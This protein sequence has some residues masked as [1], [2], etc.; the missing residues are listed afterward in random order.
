MLTLLLALTT[1]QAKP[2]TSSEFD[3]TAHTLKE[4]QKQ[5]DVFRE[6][7]FA[8]SKELELKTTFLSWV[9]GPNAGLEYAIRQNKQGALSVGANAST[10][11][12]FGSQ[13]VSGNV[14]W[15]KGGPKGNRVNLAAGVG[16]GT[17]SV[18]GERYF[19]PST[20]L[21]WSYHLSTNKKTVWRFYAE[22]DPYNAV[23]LKTFVGNAGAEWTR[24]FGDAGRVA[25]GFKYQ[26]T[27]RLVTWVDRADGDSSNLPAMLP[28]P[29]LDLFFTF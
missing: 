1:A 16:V 20:M 15:T 27:T 28:L 24:G 12:L 6:S 9:V 14:R 19:A 5:I 3:D 10:G 25:L 8:I 4:G 11:W 7:Q 18:D 13:A 23:Q 2:L 26:D 21:Y 22:A 29:S 17:A